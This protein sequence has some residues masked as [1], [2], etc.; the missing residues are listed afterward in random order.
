MKARHR[1]AVCFFCMF[2]L[3]LALPATGLAADAAE[4][5]VTADEAGSQLSLNNGSPFHVT[6]NVV[7][8]QRLIEVP[9]TA[10]LSVKTDD[11]AQIDC[12]NK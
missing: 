7:V 9:G 11:A 5:S 2:V 4:L 3:A 10:T 8:N 6:A 1:A 12:K